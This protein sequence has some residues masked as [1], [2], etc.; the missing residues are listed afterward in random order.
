MSM[1]MES[2][3][4]LLDLPQTYPNGHD[5]AGRVYVVFGMNSTLAQSR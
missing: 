2:V 5:Y 1:A 3:I 4:S